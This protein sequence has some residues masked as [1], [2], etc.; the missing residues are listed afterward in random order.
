MTSYFLAPALEQLRN[1][2][3]SR[4]PERDKT[5][6]GWIGDASHAAR[7]SDHNPCWACT[8]K[9]EGIVRAIDID[10]DDNDPKQDLRRKLLNAAIGDPRV[11]YVISNG[12]I[13]S[14][15]YG[16][17]ARHY[18]GS[19]PHDH[20]VHISLKSGV[21]EFNTEKWMDERP[22]IR[23]VAVSLEGVRQQFLNLQ[24]NRA[25]TFSNGVGRIQR[26]LNRELKLKGADR[27][28]VDGLVG[29]RTALAWAQF[30]KGLPADDRRGRKNVPDRK[31][32]PILAR[33]R[34][35]VVH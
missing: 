26:Q 27:L 17:Q 21:G 22:K 4:F 33:G 31:S 24:D 5:S 23:P 1:E 9:Y 32:L 19:N 14:A 11:W 30:E 6:D 25:V 8:G 18:D 13:Y 7:P 2:V 28:T 35:R 3:N 34:F 29:K 12:V 20:H 15:T 10:I 16:F